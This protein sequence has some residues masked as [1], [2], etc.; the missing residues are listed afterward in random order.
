MS[1]SGLFNMDVRGMMDVEAQLALL[2][3][4]RELRRRL[5]NRVAQRLRTPWRQRIRNQRDVN[6]NAFDARKHKLKKG[7]KK[8]MLSGLA[9]AL[10]VTRLTPNEAELGWRKSKMAMIG[11]THNQGMSYRVTAAQ[12]RSWKRTNPLMATRE[13]AKRLRRLGYKRERPGKNKRGKQTYM[14]PSVAWIQ[15][16]IRYNQAGLL[17]R[18][19][20]DEKLGP[21]SWEVTLPG[22]EFFGIANDQEISALIALILPQILSSPQ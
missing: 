20:K 3:L 9:K 17:I 1:R 14:R 19:L 21:T 10:D 16:N 2:S 5:L 12:V 8:R 7:Q 18:S 15:D 11:R 6:G 13:Q 22:R 4:P